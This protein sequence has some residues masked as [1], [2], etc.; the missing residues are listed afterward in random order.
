MWSNFLHLFC[1]G[2][3]SVGLGHA[4]YSL[5]GNLTAFLVTL[6]DTAGHTFNNKARE[7]AR[8]KAGHAAYTNK[9]ELE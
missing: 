1:S 7:Q 5:Q 3:P 4:L 8:V 9:P 2:Q 6:L